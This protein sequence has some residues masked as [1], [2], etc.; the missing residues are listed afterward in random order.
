MPLLAGVPT[1][2]QAKRMAD[3]LSSPAWSTPLP[4]PT[5]SRND[6]EFSS[7]TFWRGDVWPAPDFQIAT[8]L[9]A[10]GLHA[11]AERIADA[12]VAN[13][14]KAGIS[15]RYDSLTGA[16]LGVAGL[17]MSATSLSMMLDGL[18]S[19]KFNLRVRNA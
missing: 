17:G 6:P 19:A 14:L 3:T 8:G 10:Y 15:E 13:A 7:N 11:D 9:A 2:R 16:P 4:I 5:V 18:T 1:A 12:L